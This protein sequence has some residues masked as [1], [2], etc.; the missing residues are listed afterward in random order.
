MARRRVWVRCTDSRLGTRCHRSTELQETL[1]EDHS[2]WEE[3][4]TT[5]LQRHPRLRPSITK[6]DFLVG[7][8]A[9][10]VH[11]ATPAEGSARESC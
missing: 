2:Q 5:L 4:W 1:L 3:A 11:S 7:T 8:C 6:E 10:T 9:H